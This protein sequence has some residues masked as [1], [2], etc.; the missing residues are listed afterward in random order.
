[1]EKEIFEFVK[2]EFLYSCIHMVG[3]VASFIKK[4]LFFF[5]NEDVERGEIRASKPDSIGRHV[6]ELMFCLLVQK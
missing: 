4:K 3:F 5:M 6:S 1:M 2:K